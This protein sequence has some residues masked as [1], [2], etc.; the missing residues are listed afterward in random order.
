V[1]KR[2]ARALHS[3]ELNTIGASD[4]RRTDLDRERRSQL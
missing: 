2:A 4:D 3:H 1:A